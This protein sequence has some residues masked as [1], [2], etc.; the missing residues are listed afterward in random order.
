MV[1]ERAAILVLAQ[2]VELDPYRDRAGLPDCGSS[3]QGIHDVILIGV[4][5]NVQA[6]AELA[7]DPL[8]SPVK[9]S[10]VAVAGRIGRGRAG[11]FFERPVHYQ[12]RR[13]AADKPQHQG[14][15]G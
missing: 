2:A 12:L 15:G 13:G 11:T 14:N 5:A 8:G 4:A 7:L 9:G 6:S 10:V 3:G 1:G